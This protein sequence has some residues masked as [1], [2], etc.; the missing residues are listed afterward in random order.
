MVARIATAVLTIGMIEGEESLHLLRARLPTRLPALRQTCGRT[1]TP[2]VHKGLPNLL[3]RRSPVCPHRPCQSLLYPAGVIRIS[4]A[5]LRPP[6]PTSAVH[7]MPEGLVVGGRIDLSHHPTTLDQTL[8]GIA[9]AMIGEVKHDVMTMDGRSTKR[10]ADGHHL[11]NRMGFLLPHIGP[12]IVAIIVGLIAT[13][14]LIGGAKMIVRL[15]TSEQSSYQAMASVRLPGW[16]GRTYPLR[17][18]APTFPRHCPRCYHRRCP[19]THYRSPTR[20]QLRE[21]ALGHQI[22]LPLVF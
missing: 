8:A 3:R 2:I 17:S 21:S 15:M 6:R 18:L 22:R 13:R 5:V 16:A 9:M 1:S 12:L 10:Q 7:T 20:T 19:K 14:R 11:D 4:D